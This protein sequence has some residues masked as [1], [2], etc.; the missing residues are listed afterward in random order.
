M[1][2]RTKAR[3][4]KSR[5]SRGGAPL[6]TRRCSLWASR[7][8]RQGITLLE[9]LVTVSILLLLMTVALPILSPSD[10]ARQIREAARSV[11]IFL[12]AARNRAIE[13]GRPVG[14][15]FE[16]IPNLPQGCMGMRRVEIPPVYSGDGSP[17]LVQVQKVS[18]SVTN[19]SVTI[20]MNNSTQLSVGAGFLNVGDLI[21]LNYQG[22]L[23]TISSF[24]S[25]NTSVQSMTAVGQSPATLPWSNVTWSD[26]VPFEIARR[27]VPSRTPPM[28]LPPS[29]VIDLSLSGRESWNI[30]GTISTQSFNSTS[31]NN[32]LIV[33]FGPNGACSRY[34]LE[35]TAYDRS[36]P[37]YLLVGKREYVQ[38]FLTGSEHYSISD[39]SSLWIK[40]DPQNGQVSVKENVSSTNV[41]IARGLARA[42]DLKGGR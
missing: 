37:L 20:R 19:L 38:R 18:S 36:D 33:L 22:P 6:R 28:T 34:Y 2:L 17:S 16:R 21:R 13:T 27:P 25:S 40:I 1:G 29:T 10:D 23:Y 26:P 12:D 11:S 35:G 15:S 42:T 9:L 39:V 14:V 32:P 31:S 4:G 3:R 30:N 41:T 7:P 5:R 8:S 24:S